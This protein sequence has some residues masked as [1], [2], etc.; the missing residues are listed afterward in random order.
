MTDVKNEPE[1]E[2][3]KDGYIYYMYDRKNQRI[4]VGCS[5]MRFS[6]RMADHRYDY[7]AYMGQASPSLVRNYR[8]SFDIII[9]EEY[10]TGILEKFPCNSKK[11]L[12]YR[13]YEWIT[14]LNEK[15]DLEVVNIWKRNIKKPQLNHSFFQ[16]PFCIAK[17]VS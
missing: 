5:R 4:Y 12:E 7:K 13:E 3:Y 10:E 6:K 15:E 9:Q 2:R 11:E 16:L 8:T 17:E 1:D 14:A